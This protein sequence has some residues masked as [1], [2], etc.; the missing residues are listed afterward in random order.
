MFST[1]P[2]IIGTS[3]LGELRKISTDPTSI[4]SFAINYQLQLEHSA[5]V[6]NYCEY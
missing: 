1:L 2:N 5:V 4:P 3:K 6:Q